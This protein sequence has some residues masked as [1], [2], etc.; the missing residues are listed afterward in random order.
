VF[1][2][3]DPASARPSYCTVRSAGYCGHRA[4]YRIERILHKGASTPQVP[5][6]KTLSHSV[7]APRALPFASPTV[8]HHRFLSFLT[9]WSRLHPCVQVRT[10]Q[11]P[12]LPSPRPCRHA[13][14][15]ALTRLCNSLTQQD[16][17]REVQNLREQIYRVK[18]TTVRSPDA[19]FTSGY[20]PYACE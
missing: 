1:H 8:T 12:P 13:R 2:P 19:Y 15:L 11:S 6:A 5:I 10:R 17:L 20:L 4:V 18:G 7:T 3:S 16:G 9:G 14:T